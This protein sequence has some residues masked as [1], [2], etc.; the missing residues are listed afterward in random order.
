MALNK[1][2]GNMYS[3]VDFTWN[4]IKG[5]CEQHDCI[6]CYMKQFKLNPVRLDEGELKVNL[7]LHRKIFVGSSTD[8]WAED[9]PTR[10]ISL[11]LMHAD[12][13]PNTYYYQSKNPKRFSEFD[14]FPHNFLG[15]TIETN[16]ID[17][18]G[19]FSTAPLVNK[20]FAAMRNIKRLRKKTFITIEPIMDFDVIDFA[21][22]LLYCQPDFVNIGADSKRH[23]LPEP[24]WEKVQELI[25][26]L[27]KFTEVR[28]KS[29]LERLKHD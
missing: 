17:Y 15:T 1:S 12:Q 11:S 2:K 19:D 24:S 16:R 27:S 8:M 13:Y 9:I 22:E 28:Q 6:Y 26:E 23:N 18:D 21:K 5:K 3:F 7:G 4:P 10:W 20:R 14:I 25:V 29:N